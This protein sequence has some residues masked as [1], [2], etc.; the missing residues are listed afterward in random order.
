MVRLGGQAPKQF[1]T[2]EEHH[3]KGTRTRRKH[4]KRQEKQGK[5]WS[6][7]LFPERRE[8][9]KRYGH[10]CHD[11]RRTRQ[12]DED[13]TLFR[14]QEAWAYITQLPGQ[15]QEEHA[16]PQ[17]DDGER[18]TRAPPGLDGRYGWRR[19]LGVFQGG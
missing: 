19:S 11:R 2:H 1:H 6:T 18:T 4:D 10:R 5:Q 7:I 17:E 3:R 16:A 13:R 12:D 8:R 9:P 15:E 14:M